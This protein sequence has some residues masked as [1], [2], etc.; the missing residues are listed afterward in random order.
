ML[1]RL[2]SVKCLQIGGFLATFSNMQVLRASSFFFLSIRFWCRC[3]FLFFCFCSIRF[4]FTIQIS[5]FLLW[6]YS[7]CRVIHVDSFRKGQM[8]VNWWFSSNILTICKCYVFIPWLMVRSLC[9][10]V[11]L[12]FSVTLYVNIGETSSQI[13]L[14]K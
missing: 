2:N 11:I 4:G 5:A 13:S 3:F 7:L 8:S 1:I 14:I 6:I 9:L 10:L 12:T